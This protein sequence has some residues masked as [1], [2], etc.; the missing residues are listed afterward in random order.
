MMRCEGK[1][2]QG[3]I[4]VRCR[5]VW[6]AVLVLGQILALPVALEAAASL[7]VSTLRGGLTL[8]LGGLDAHRA[9]THEEVTIKMS[10]SPAS[11]Y[12]LVSEV[13]S[14]LINEAGTE[15]DP[16]RIMVE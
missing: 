7:T 3:M 12:H 6:V 4:V 11:Q 14:P 15:L 16:L 1:L 8:D 5:A 10:T 13:S 9:S 2:T